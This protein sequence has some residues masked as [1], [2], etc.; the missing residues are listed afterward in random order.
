MTQEYK[1]LGIDFYSHDYF[2]PLSKGRRIIGVKSL[3]D[4][5]RKEIVIGITCWEL[6]SHSFKTLVLLTFT[7]GIKIWRGDLKTLMGKF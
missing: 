4:T 3:R 2:E 7:C 5:L 1:Y 6:Y